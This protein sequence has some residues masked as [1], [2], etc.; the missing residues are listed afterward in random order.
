M[1]C[2]MH[3][4]NWESVNGPAAH[5]IEGLNFINQVNLIESLT[6][7]LIEAGKHANLPVPLMPSEMALQELHRCGTI[8]LL[9]KPGEYRDDEVVVKEG[10]TV[11]YRPPPADTVPKHMKAL[12]EELRGIWHAGDALDVAAF[13]LWRIN[14]VHPFKN[15]NGRTARAF[16]Y[17][18]LSARLGVI[19]PGRTTVIDQIMRN[20][21][22]YES[23]LRIADK[24][25]EANNGR[26]LAP[27]REYLDKLL[28]IQMDSV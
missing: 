1:D 22:E 16:C 25:A 10:D 23:C 28:Q 19:L 11:V 15:G 13:V 8:F 9:A 18:C 17:A 26:N 24:A 21:D 14:W 12:F 3:D 5:K 6:V 20:R 27:M 4:D 2:E 7:L